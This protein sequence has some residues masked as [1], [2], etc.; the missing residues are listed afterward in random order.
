MHNSSNCPALQFHIYASIW[1]TV[2]I[3]FGIVSITI[4]VV[5]KRFQ[6]SKDVQVQTDAMFDVVTI[7]HP[8]NTY[9]F[10][11]S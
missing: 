1:C 4:C 9:E 10:V 11:A 6:R 2:F 7:V 3:L 8:Y 5:H